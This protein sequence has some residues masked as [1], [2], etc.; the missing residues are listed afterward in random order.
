MSGKYNQYKDQ[1]GAADFV[2]FAGSVAIVS[3][4][5]GPKVRTVSLVTFLISLHV[6]HYYPQVV[7]RKDSSTPAPD[8]LLPA[9]FGPN[10]S[11]DVLLQLFEDKGISGDELAALIGAHTA[12]KAVAQEANGIPP[13]GE[14][15]SYSFLLEG[16][17]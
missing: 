12:S 17:S 9:A 13:G 2:Q 5:G 11:H 3:C 4:P 16:F 15:P 6:T 14:S 8:G 7:G 10:S 1:V